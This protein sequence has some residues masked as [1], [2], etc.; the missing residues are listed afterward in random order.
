MFFDKEGTELFVEASGYSMSGPIAFVHTHNTILYFATEN[1]VIFCN[2]ANS[3]YTMQDETTLVIAH[4]QG[5]SLTGNIGCIQVGGTRVYSQIA[6]YRYRGTNNMQTGTGLTGCR[7]LI[8]DCETSVTLTVDATISLGLILSNGTLINDATSPNLNMA[9]DSSIY[10]HSGSIYQPLLFAGNISNFYYTA[11][12]T[13]SELNSTVQDLIID[14]GVDANVFLNR[15]VTVNRQLNLRNGIL[16]IGANFLELAGETN[17]LN[18]S[19]VGGSTS[20][21]VISG[22]NTPYVVE[23]FN[24][25]LNILGMGRTNGFSMRGDIQIDGF[26]FTYLDCEQHSDPIYSLILNNEA[27]LGGQGYW[28]GRVVQDIGDRGFVS[29]PLGIKI[30]AGADVTDFSVI[31]RKEHYSYGS[32]TSIQR[33]WSIEGIPSGATN[34]TLIWPASADNGMNFST[35]NAQVWRNSGTG[36]S[37]YGNHQAVNGDPREIAILTNSFSEWTVA[38]EDQTLPVELSSFMVFINAGNMVCLR[39]VTQSE[40]NVNGFSIYRGVSDLLSEAMSLNVFIQATNTSNTQSYQYVDD[41]LWESGTYYYWL[42]VQDL[43]GSDTIHGPLQIFIDDPNH[44]IPLPPILEG[45]AAIYP[46]PFNPSVTIKYVIETD[47]EANLIIYNTKGQIVRSLVKGAQKTGCY[48]LIWD[49]RDALGKQA[50]S[51]VYILKLN[52][53]S[54]TWT[55]KLVLSK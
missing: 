30:Q 8:I 6:D 24:L 26:V 33:M 7:N 53:G 48:N 15:N 4:A 16:H 31:H 43:D 25:H 9:S 42:E 5:I 18:G 37:R 38:D 19:L 13:G 36:W 49:G 35:R 46:N 17:Y 40:T 32:S 12:T 14:A 3:T 1:S 22:G 34:L 52:I 55:A 28:F 20:N 50:A 21:M 10:R 41:D 39:W 54:K 29:Y 23:L 27:T 44:P 2:N 45:L 51:G 47:S 11:C